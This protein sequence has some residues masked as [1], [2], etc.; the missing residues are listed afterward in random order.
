TF[1]DRLELICGGSIHH[2]RPKPLRHFVVMQ[3][4]WS[5]AGLVQ[6]DAFGPFPDP[7]QEELAGYLADAPGRRAHLNIVRRGRSKAKGFGIVRDD[8]HEEPTAFCDLQ[9]AEGAGL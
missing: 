6:L 8:P 4:L 7:I 2:I 1:R 9:L 3:Y 5:L